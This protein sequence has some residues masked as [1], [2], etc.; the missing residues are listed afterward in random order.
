MILG[1]SG[2]GKTTFM[3]AVM[4]YE[5]ADGKILYGDKDIYTDYEKM[6]YQIGYVPQ[7]DLLRGSDTVYDTVNDA[8]CL[9]LPRKTSK[10]ERKQRIEKVLDILN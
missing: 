5:K 7:Q 8:A 3:N 1:G 4:G 10:E 9:K 2:A 6:K